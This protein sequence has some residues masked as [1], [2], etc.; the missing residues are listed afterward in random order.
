MYIATP[1]IT[2]CNSLSYG[3]FEHVIMCRMPLMIIYFQ[4]GNEENVLRRVHTS[5]SFPF[6][7]HANFLG[8]GSKVDRFD[9]HAVGG[10]K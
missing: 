9:P 7:L 5:A 4:F 8:S 10:L 2:Q 6:A 1:C 3:L